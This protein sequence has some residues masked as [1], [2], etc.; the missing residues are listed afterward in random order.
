MKPRAQFNNKVC[1]E[2]CASIGW[3]SSFLFILTLF[4][5]I[6]NTS[7]CSSTRWF[8]ILSFPKAW[9]TWTPIFLVR[10]EPSGQNLAAKS[11]CKTRKTGII[12]LGRDFVQA[13]SSWAHGRDAA[14]GKSSMET[15][16]LALLPNNKSKFNPQIAW[17]SFLPGTGSYTNCP[18]ALSRI[19]WP[20]KN[21]GPTA[22]MEG[23]K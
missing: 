16:T 11:C 23:C 6:P 20:H 1:S 22:A 19:S 14:V 5:A 4:L 12:P 10:G 13:G 17:A 8:P 2:A 7:L 9:S 15:P 21:R 18:S 3:F